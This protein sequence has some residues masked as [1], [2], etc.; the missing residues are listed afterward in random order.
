MRYR[1]DIK[2]KYNSSKNAIN[3]KEIAEYLHCIKHTTIISLQV[4]QQNSRLYILFKIK[5]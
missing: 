2:W 4:T 1:E 3:R 5:Y